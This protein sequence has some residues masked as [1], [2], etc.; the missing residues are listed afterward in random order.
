MFYKLSEEYI[1]AF[2]LRGTNF[3]EKMELSLAQGL[4]KLTTIIIFGQ[5]YWPAQSKTFAELNDSKDIIEKK[6]VI[7]G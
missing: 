7:V 4:W 6:T 5:I 2:L 1:K 3:D